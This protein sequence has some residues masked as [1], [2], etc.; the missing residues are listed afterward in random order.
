MTSHIGARLISQTEDSLQLTKSENALKDLTPKR[1]RYV[2]S[3]IKSCIQILQSWAL[4][5]EDEK[6]LYSLSSGYHAPKD[7]E[8]DLMNAEV[9]SRKQQEEFV[10]D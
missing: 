7:T 1:V 3:K 4:M 10:S 6:S 8:K 5:F 2:K 9:I